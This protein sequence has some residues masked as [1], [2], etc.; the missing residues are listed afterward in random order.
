MKLTELAIHINNFRVIPRTMVLG[1]GIL[2]AQSVNWFQG[3]VIPT[4]Q[5]VSLIS[6]IVGMG[7]VV[8]AFYV[9]TGII[10]RTS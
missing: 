2:L 5:Q 9:N 4:T 1:Y 3:L 6:T 10:K 8:F 7:A